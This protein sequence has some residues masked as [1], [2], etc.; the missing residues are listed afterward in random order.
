VVRQCDH[1][2]RTC[3]SVRSSSDV[4]RR[5]IA[6][7]PKTAYKVYKWLAFVVGLASVVIAGLNTNDAQVL[8]ALV[9]ANGVVNFFGAAIGKAAEDNTNGKA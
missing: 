4:G 9:I 3:Q 6:R 5:S 7:G 2:R 8:M 1:F